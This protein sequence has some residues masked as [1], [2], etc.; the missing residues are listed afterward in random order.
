M[1]G[2]ATQTP[3]SGK[4]ES[5]LEQTAQGGTQSNSTVCCSNRCSQHPH[6]QPKRARQVQIGLCGCA[7]QCVPVIASTELA[8][9]A[10]APRACGMTKGDAVCRPL[11]SATMGESGL[12]CC[13]PCADMVSGCRR[14]I[15]G[16]PSPSGSAS[17]A[18]GGVPNSASMPNGSSS[19]ACADS[20]RIWNAASNYRWIKSHCLI[21]KEKGQS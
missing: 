12:P 8:R 21:S 15:P 4:V 1:T 18:P 9:R 6:L 13:T 10:W 5:P 2:P 14:P 19:P 3:S 7:M 11:C 16:R 20:N 17:S